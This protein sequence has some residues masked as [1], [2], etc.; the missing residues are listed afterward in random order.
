M[1]EDEDNWWVNKNPDNEKSPSESMNVFTGSV[2]SISSQSPDISI[3]PNDPN[4]FIMSQFLI[5]LLIIPIF[6]GF[7]TS[8]VTISANKSVN[9]TYYDDY[10]YFSDDDNPG[11]TIISGDEY[12]TWDVIFDVPDIDI[13][14]IEERD[15]WLSIEFRAAE[16]DSQWGYCYFDMDILDNNELKKS[17]DGSYWY[18]MYCS[19]S[20]E[21]YEV[22]FQVTEQTF[23]YAIDQNIQAEYASIYG[24]TD[25]S[26]FGIFLQIL[27]ILIILFYI[28]VIVWSFISKRKSLGFGLIGGI[29]IVPISFCFS[30]IFISFFYWNNF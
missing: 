9:D 1:V 17:G 28:G 14:D 5:G 18:P 2:G 4:K 15:Y 27:P 12:Y 3:M 21:E 25:I 16:E 10:Y 22:L 6:A 30:M 20:M 11:T 23:T 13:S 19:H 29:I 7:I 8:V 24:D 26:G